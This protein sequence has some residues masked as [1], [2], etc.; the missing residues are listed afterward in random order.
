MVTLLDTGLLEFVVPI[1]TFILIY[2]LIFAILK[3]VKVLGEN[4]S[5]NMWVSFALAILFA[6]TPGAMEFVTIIAPWFIVL[7]VVA[8]AVMLVFMFMGANDKT[9][10]NIMHDGTVKW[11]ILIIGIIIL[12][13][14]L[15]A[16]Y[17]PVL[18]GPSPD[19]GTVGGQV[20]RSIFNVKVITTVF[21]LLI[22][23]FAIKFLS[24]EVTT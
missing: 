14:G 6:I 24:Y 23:A 18:S 20:H 9:L 15:T 22:F 12:V 13:A 1:F 5:I 4:N 16:V 3:K 11:T 17:G 2:A 7:V 10:I 21:V 8:F 19:A